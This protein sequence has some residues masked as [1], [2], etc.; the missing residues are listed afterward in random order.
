VVDI[1]PLNGRVFRFWC[2]VNHTTDL[3]TQQIILNT[4]ETCYDL[5][6]NKIESLGVKVLTKKQ[7]FKISEEIDDSHAI[8]LK[9]E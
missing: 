5:L 4:I 8:N 3:T 2:R 9:I 1:N 6:V 7:D